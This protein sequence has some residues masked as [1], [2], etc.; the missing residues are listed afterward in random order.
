MFIP[1]APII[2]REEILDPLRLFQLP[3][4]FGTQ[5]NSNLMFPNVF[6]RNAM[7]CFHMLLSFEAIVIKLKLD[8]TIS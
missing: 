4:L 7:H 1:P 8:I 2:F 3:C 5:K 6:F